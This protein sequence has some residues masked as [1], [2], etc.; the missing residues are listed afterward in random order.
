MEK[1][2]TSDVRAGL[3]WKTRVQRCIL[4]IPVLWAS[5]QAWRLPRH[6]PIS[7]EHGKQ[8]SQHKKYDVAM[9][10]ESMGKPRSSI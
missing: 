7:E 6:A 9:C 8:D 2:S 10:S 1:N 5:Q 4:K 3:T